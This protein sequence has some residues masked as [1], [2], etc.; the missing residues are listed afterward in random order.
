M[1]ATRAIGSGRVGAMRPAPVLEQAFEPPTLVSNTPTIIDSNL[2]ALNLNNDINYQ[3]YQQQSQ[4][5]QQPANIPVSSNIVNG[6]PFKLP[7]IQ[8]RLTKNRIFFDDKLKNNAIMNENA[9]N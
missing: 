2:N 7:S 5:R 8:E 3:Q 9:N 1:E 6:V 4:Q